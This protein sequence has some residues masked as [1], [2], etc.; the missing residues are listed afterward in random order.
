MVLILAGL[1]AALVI[2][3]RSLGS[4]GQSLPVTAEWIDELS[5]ERYRPMLRLL[6]SRDL[7]FLRTQP[8]YSPQMEAKLRAQRCQIFRG[9][10]RC[11]NMDFRR[12]CMALKLVMVQS[13]QDR[14]DLASILMHHQI[15]FTSGMIAIQAR[16]FLY[17]WG[18]CTVD[19][20][21]LV[22]IFDVMRLELRNMMPAAVPAV[23]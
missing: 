20:S 5:V 7:E 17:R 21:S 8:G 1:V 15:M 19:V 11:L 23:A 16:L 6:D 10:L 12:V 13:R 3:T 18:I 4:A 22:Q 14:P 9:Y 2:L